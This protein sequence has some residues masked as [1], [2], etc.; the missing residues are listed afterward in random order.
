M[1]KSLC[2]VEAPTT[3]CETSL[4]ATFVTAPLRLF[5][6]KA[7]KNSTH[8]QTTKTCHVTG[9]KTHNAPFPLRRISVQHFAEVITSRARIRSSKNLNRR[10]MK[11][12]L[13]MLSAH[14]HLKSHVLTF[15]PFKKVQS[16]NYL[17]VC[18]DSLNPFASKGVVGLD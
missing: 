2:I 3:V 12:C 7:R 9:D 16:G 6:T 1:L 18:F 5:H 14:I 11:A 8:F 4:V 15:A 13:Q 10:Q 17:K